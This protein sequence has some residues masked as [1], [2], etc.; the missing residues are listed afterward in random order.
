M[1]RITESMGKK[2]ETKDRITEVPVSTVETKTFPKPPVDAVEA[3][4]VAPE[5]PDIR[6]A[7]PPPAI[8]AKAQVTIEL[9]SATVDIITMV[10]AKAAKGTAILSSKLSI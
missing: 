9:K 3:K 4:R 8:I 6:L 2:T 10:P 7:V 5:V 1:T